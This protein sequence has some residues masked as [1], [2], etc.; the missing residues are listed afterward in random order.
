MKQKTKYN[1]IIASLLVGIVAI[2][3][4]LKHVLTDKNFTV[5]QNILSVS[6]R[7]NTGAAWSILEGKVMLLCVLTIVFLFLL[8]TFDHY[9]KH[10]NTLYAVAYGLVLG[11][12][13]GNLFDRMVFGYVKDFIK[14]DFINFPIFNIADMA[15]TA[16]VICFLVFFIFFYNTGEKQKKWTK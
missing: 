4:I 1:I 12:A 10:K 7:Q 5:L 6:Y 14:L 11:G 15:L 3:Q 13:V 9:F 2:D 8:V 16:G